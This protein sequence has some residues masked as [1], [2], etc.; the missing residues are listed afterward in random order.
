MTGQRDQQVALELH[1]IVSKLLSHD[2]MLLMLPCQTSH[3]QPPS[4][5]S[6]KHSGTGGEHTRARV[7]RWH[8]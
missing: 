3:T 8:H 1:T 4:Q 7:R 2:V 5:H 6:P